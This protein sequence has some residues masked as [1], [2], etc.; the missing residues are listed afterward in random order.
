MNIAELLDRP[1]AFH[2]SFVRLN[3]G[4][5][6][7]LLLSQAVYWSHRT[8]DADGWFFKSRDEWIDE[9]GLT[10]YEQEGARQR[11]RAIGV[12]EEELRGVPAR[13]FY[14]VD[15]E[16][17]ERLLGADLSPT[18]WRKTTQL[19]GGKPPNKK[20]GF[21]PPLKEETTT[22][23]TTENHRDPHAEA[24]CRTPRE[25]LLEALDEEHA[26]AVVD[27]R[28]K[29]RKPLTAH[30]AKLLATK[31]RNCADPNAAADAM[32]AN[33]WQGFEPEW[34]ENRKSRTNGQHRADP[35]MEHARSIAAR[36]E[37]G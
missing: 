9:T 23:T 6:G 27:H 11:L 26:S 10:R 21:P 30:A 3:V 4:I 33:G 8:N 34:L 12:L 16:A 1:I 31:F 24:A 7:A 5:S 18:S 32:I 22:E 35:L 19:V 14:R 36:K 15:F 17:L 2:R 29:I 20:A 37:G 25:E 13:L 28:R